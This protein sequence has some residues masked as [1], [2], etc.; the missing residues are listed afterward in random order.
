MQTMIREA[1]TTG[2]LI[3][4]LAP[5]AF[6]GVALFAAWHA[7]RQAQIIS[8]TQA[9]PIGMA[10]DG[11]RKFQGTIEAVAG[12]TIVAPLT[13]SPCVWYDARVEKWTR[14]TTGQNRRY[15]WQTV[16]HVTSTVPFFVRDATGVCAIDVDGAEVTPTDKSQW[17]GATLEPTDRNPPRVGPSQSTHG[18]VQTA[19]GAEGQFRYSEERI[20]AGD[21]LLVVGAFASHRFGRDDAAH[22][23]G[24]DAEDDQDDQDEDIDD[25]ETD[26]ADGEAAGASEDRYA[27]A[28][29]D[30]ER[31]EALWEQA[32]EVTKATIGA[33]GRA[34]P[35]ILTT[36]SE[37]A[38]VAMTEMGSQA[39]FYIAL[40][41]LG[42][43]ALVV[44][45]R[46]S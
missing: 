1:S 19:G 24:T 9:A 44:L 4:V 25:S 3:M 13:G 39:A 17:T 7:R 32:T 21:P 26:A 14:R 18:F 36:T 43:A 42:I 12:Q 15:E 35:L 38:H 16:R 10:E 20:Y 34:Q 33:G 37:A 6:A 40:I 23:D 31:A 5:L 11:Y 28:A 45:V 8:G 30:A 22:A 27:W 41:P 46:F 29:S 2:F